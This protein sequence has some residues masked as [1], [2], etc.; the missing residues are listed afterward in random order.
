MTEAR[1][2]RILYATD[3][4][5]GSEPA[6]HFA[7]RLAQEYGAALFFLHVVEDVWKESISTRVDADD[8]S[9]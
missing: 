2:Q 8:F 4:S 1:L 7:P 5:A 3:F 9:G 6:M